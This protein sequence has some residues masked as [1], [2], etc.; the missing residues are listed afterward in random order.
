MTLMLP[1]GHPNRRLRT[2]YKY[3]VKERQIARE[4]WS[5]TR[6]I[7]FL[8]KDYKKILCSNKPDKNKRLLKIRFKIRAQKYLKQRLVRLLKGKYSPQKKD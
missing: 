8:K 3:S 2:H 1:E 5:A 4:V 7:T 6:N